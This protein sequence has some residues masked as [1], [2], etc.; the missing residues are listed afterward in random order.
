MKRILPFALLLATAPILA[1]QAPSKFHFGTLTD[2]VGDCTI[3]KTATS[4][5]LH[6][7]GSHH[8]LAPDLHVT[9]APRV[10]KPMADANFKYGVIVSGTFDPGTES[11]YPE[12]FAYTGAG[13]VLML[14]DGNFFTLFHG[15]FQRPGEKQLA[16]YVSAGLCVDGKVVDYGSITDQPVPP[17]S[18]VYLGFERR[19][20]NLYFMTSPDGVKWRQLGTKEIPANWPGTLQI[21]V[22]ATSTSKREFSPSFSQ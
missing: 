20:K 17:N 11:T 16:S 8:D 21:G 4:F 22:A 18:P 7:P 15:V 19:G 3:S 1:A 12:R 5:T 10:L 13:L 14:D 9:N 2:P 6:V